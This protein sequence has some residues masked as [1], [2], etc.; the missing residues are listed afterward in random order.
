M[1]VPN[2]PY[3]NPFGMGIRGN[4]FVAANPLT[5]LMVSD[6]SQAAANFA[7]FYGQPVVGGRG[8]RTAP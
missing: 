8:V 3:P 6:R 5:G 4:G 1:D 2:W 7:D